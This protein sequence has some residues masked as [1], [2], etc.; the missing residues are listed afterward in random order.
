MLINKLDRPYISYIARFLAAFY[1][2]WNLDCL[3]SYNFGI[4]LQTDTLAT[5]SLDLAV[6]TYPLLLMVITLLIVISGIETGRYV[7]H[8]H[9]LCTIRIVLF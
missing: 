6:A 2:V 8:V 5:L 1:G 7:V 3:R 9:T 4:C